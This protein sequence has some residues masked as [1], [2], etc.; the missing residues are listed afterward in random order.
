[1]RM[2]ALARFWNFYQKYIKNHLH[3][4]KL[5]KGS[6]TTSMFVLFRVSEIPN[7]KLPEQ[8]DMC[9]C[10][11]I[12]KRSAPSRD[13]SRVALWEPLSKKVQLT[14]PRVLLEAHSQ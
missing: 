7:L 11:D 6:A 12:L 14:P 9:R 10:G 8:V 5:L 13:A 1:M 4:E 2:T 3:V